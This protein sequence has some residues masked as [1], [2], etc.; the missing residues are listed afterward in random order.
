VLD[1]HP[2]DVPTNRLVGVIGFG[3]VTA[4]GICDER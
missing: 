4:T 3:R 1:Y 2:G